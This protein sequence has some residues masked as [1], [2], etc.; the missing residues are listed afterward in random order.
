MVTRVNDVF[1]FFAK[2]Q[3]CMRFCGSV[4]LVEI[5]FGRQKWRVDASKGRYMTST[6]VV[7]SSG[8]YGGGGDGGGGGDVKRFRWSSLEQS[9]FL[10]SGKPVRFVGVS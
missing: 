9:V 2:R 8:R 10:R 3:A 6:A 7:G 5:P 4:L 1:F